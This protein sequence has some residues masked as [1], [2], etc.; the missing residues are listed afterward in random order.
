MSRGRLHLLHAPFCP[1]SPQSF[2]HDLSSGSNFQSPVY[3]AGLS[4]SPNAIYLFWVTCSVLN[5]SDAS[6]DCSTAPAAAVVG[7]MEE[8]EVREGWPSSR[9]PTQRKYLLL[10][11]GGGRR[12]GPGRSR[13]FSC[14]CYHILDTIGLQKSSISLKVTGVIVVR[15]SLSILITLGPKIILP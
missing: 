12:R 15:A 11:R 6:V 1:S 8:E 3:A 13:R 14:S 5:C 7:E 4:H 10:Q 9:R 2:S